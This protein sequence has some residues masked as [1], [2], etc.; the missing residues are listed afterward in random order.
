MR[1]KTKAT[2]DSNAIQ[3]LVPTQINSEAGAAAVSALIE[4]TE[5]LVFN[6]MIETTTETRRK[7]KPQSTSVIGKRKINKMSKH[8]IH[9]ATPKRK[10][11]PVKKCFEDGRIQDKNSADNSILPITTTVIESDVMAASGKKTKR[12]G[13]SLAVKNE[14]KRVDQKLSANKKGML[15]TRSRKQSKK[16]ESPLSVSKPDAIQACETESTSVEAEQR[17]DLVDSCISAAA[18][19]AVAVIGVE[20]PSQSEIQTLTAVNDPDTIDELV[21]GLNCTSQSNNDIDCDVDSEIPTDNR[22]NRE[23]PEITDL[24]IRRSPL[25]I[26]NPLPDVFEE[27]I[28]TEPSQENLAEVRIISYYTLWWCINPTSFP[29]FQ[30]TLVFIF[31]V[32]RNKTNNKKISTKCNWID[33]ICVAYARRYDATEGVAAKI[34]LGC[35]HQS[36]CMPQLQPSCSAALLPMYKVVEGCGRL[37]KVMEGCGSL[38]MLAPSFA[39]QIVSACMCQPV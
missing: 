28:P 25:Q 36:I 11:S 29:G 34:A 6:E 35:N 1:S 16:Q 24:S 30:L 27:S 17:M 22:N 7:H 13:V 9:E 19:T 10:S 38:W 8:L 21:L 33:F 5:H 18:A 4:N 32:V 15:E 26:E 14:S 3:E 31:G 12:K 2:P 39:K 37:W 23:I 20:S